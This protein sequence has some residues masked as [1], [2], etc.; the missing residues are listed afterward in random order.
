[1]SPTQIR[2]ANLQMWKL[3]CQY[4][5][6][7]LL[8]FNRTMKAPQL[9]FLWSTFSIATCRMSSFTLISPNILIIQSPKVSSNWLNSLFDENRLT[10]LFSRFI[11]ELW[12]KPWM[13]M[14]WIGKHWLKENWVWK[15]L[16]NFLP[17]F[18]SYYS[19]LHG[20]FNREIVYFKD[21]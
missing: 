6:I 13:N 2:S 10:F 11:V 4:N 17:C 12:F 16:I 19:I 21:A 5:F 8:F 18:F 7:W 15:F 1:M 9:S 14:I 3:K 20:S